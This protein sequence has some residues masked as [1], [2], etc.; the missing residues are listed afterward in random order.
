MEDKIVTIEFKVW[1]ADEA[2]G[3]ALSQ[4][5]GAFVDE[6]GRMGKKVTAVK[7]AEAMSKWKD[8]LLVRQAILKH[9]S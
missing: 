5:M 3:T 7:L 4:A 1:A 6:L 8:N 9:F 2:E